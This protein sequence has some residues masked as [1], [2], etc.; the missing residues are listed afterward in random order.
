MKSK[1]KLSQKQYNSILFARLEFQRLILD[2][3][4]P[5]EN[6][7]YWEH[8]KIAGERFDAAE[9]EFEQ[10]IYD[11]RQKTKQENSVPVVVMMR[12]TLLIL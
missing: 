11:K 8:R 1:F 10:L 2:Y 5:P 6:E 3:A 7:V 4:D 12:L 9:G